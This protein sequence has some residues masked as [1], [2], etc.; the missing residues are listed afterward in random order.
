MRPLS[1]AEKLARQDSLAGHALALFVEKGYAKLTT[2]AVAQRSGM[3]KGTLFLTFGS[4]EELILHG[5]RRRFEAWHDRLEAID[6]RLSP[7]QLAIAM[8]ESL[9]ADPLLMPLLPLVCPVLEKGSSDAAIIQFKA[10]LVRRFDGLAKCWAP[11]RPMVPL[12]AWFPLFFRIYALTVGALSLGDLSPGVRAALADDPL[13]HELPSSFEE[14]CL[15]M[16]EAQ[17]RAVL[18]D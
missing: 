12:D 9:R 3:A 15:P 4:K 8:L 11:L 6:P 16:L 5:I 14:L 2:E 18:G 13:F 1:D 17:L 7:A 10:A